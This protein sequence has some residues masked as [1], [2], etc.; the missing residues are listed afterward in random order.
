MTE[1][2]DIP[3]AIVH[4]KMKESFAAS[5]CFKLLHYFSCHNKVFWLREANSYLITYETEA[6]LA[7]PLPAES[8]STA[9]AGA[10]SHNG[11]M[12]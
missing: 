8:D 5:F 10:P 1:H 9:A 3:T 4:L 7:G 11:L 6:A 2:T 12:L